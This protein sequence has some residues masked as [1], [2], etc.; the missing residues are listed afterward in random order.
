VPCLA[1]PG[2]KDPLEALVLR[3][4]PDH[5]VVMEHLEQLEERDLPV[6][7]AL[8]VRLV[9]LVLLV[10][11]VLPE[12]LEHL[13][14]LEPLVE[15]A[16]LE[17]LD[18]LEQVVKLVRQ[19]RRASPGTPVSMEH[20]VPPEAL[21]S[22]EPLVSR[23][24]VATLDR[25][26]LAEQLAQQVSRVNRVQPELRVQLVTLGRSG[27]PAIRVKRDH[28]EQLVSPEQRDQRDQQDPK[29]LSEPLEPLEIQDSLVNRVNKD[30][31]DR[32]DLRVS[33]GRRDPREQLEQLETL[34]AVGQED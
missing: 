16:S 27:R 34:A 30:L 22:L 7:R 23:A 31:P 4:I 10:Q 9:H 19:D 18:T 29:V 1:S 6:P 21:D 14:L 32:L 13:V 15:P 24:A 3:E 5:V 33:L 25:L 17:K 2:R 11:P 8:L 26:E 12:Q 20:Q 28:K